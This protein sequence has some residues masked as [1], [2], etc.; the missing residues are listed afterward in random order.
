MVL[1]YHINDPMYKF[2]IVYNRIRDG[3][4]RRRWGHRRLIL[5]KDVDPEFVAELLNEK[6]IEVP[7]KYRQ[8]EKKWKKT[9]T[10]D[11]LDVLKYG[12]ALWDL[13][14]GPLRESGRLTLEAP[15][16]EPED[17]EAVAA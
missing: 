12:A 9:G 11:Y 2:E 16:P 13:M 6:R 14:E 10:N 5:P 8:I 3:K 7:N 15:P 17:E 4:K 1:T